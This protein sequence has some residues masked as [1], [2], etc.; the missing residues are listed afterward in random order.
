MPH[1]AQ[2]RPLLQHNRRGKAR[3]NVAS[4]MKQIR[5]SVN[6]ALTM[7]YDMSQAAKLDADSVLSTGGEAVDTLATRVQ[8]ALNHADRLKFRVRKCRSRERRWSNSS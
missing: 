4:K 7:S 6:D 2:L 8:I 3:A 1:V 5:E